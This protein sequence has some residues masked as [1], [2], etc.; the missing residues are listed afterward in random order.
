M[1]ADDF[2]STG[3]ATLEVKTLDK[4]NKASMAVSAKLNELSALCRQEG[5]THLKFTAFRVRVPI[6]KI[7][8]R[9]LRF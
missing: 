4:T 3:S 8:L 1:G 6:T 2:I 9:G 7:T 5:I